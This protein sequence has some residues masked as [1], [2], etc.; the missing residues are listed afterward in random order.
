MPINKLF[1]WDRVWD[2]L[3]ITAQ[4]L[5]HTHK[6]ALIWL[7]WGEK[8]LDLFSHNTDTLSHSQRMTSE[9]GCASLQTASYVTITH[10][11]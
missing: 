1:M 4:T 11:Q 6:P 2:S 7:Q 9:T 3:S 5:T 10:D 8:D